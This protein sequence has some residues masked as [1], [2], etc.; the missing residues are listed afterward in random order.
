MEKCS[1]QRD[2]YNFG[3]KATWVCGVS[4]D[5]SLNLSTPLWSVS[6]S[7]RFLEIPLKV[8]CFLTAFGNAM[9]GLGHPLP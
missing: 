1:L 4:T 5:L 7:I 6:P 3:D 2:R 9:S 8:D